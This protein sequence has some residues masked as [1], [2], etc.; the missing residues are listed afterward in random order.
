M[1]I[2]K[3]QVQSTVAV[4][5]E[6]PNIKLVDGYPPAHKEHLAKLDQYKKIVY[7]VVGFV[8]SRAKAYPVIVWEVVRNGWGFTYRM[9]QSFGTAMR[10]GH[11]YPLAGPKIHDYETGVVGVDRVEYTGR[12]MAAVTVSAVYGATF[13]FIAMGRMLL[14]VGKWLG[15]LLWAGIVTAAFK[16]LFA[17]VLS[18]M[19]IFALIWVWSYVSLIDPPV[20]IGMASLVFGFLGYHKS[21]HFPGLKHWFNSGV[22]KAIG[23]DKKKDCDC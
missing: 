17:L 20:V 9:M 10:D 19:A 1:G 16:G 12:L 21:K 6:K 23:E 5:Q 11:L 4:D 18:V 3:E 7:D 13:L 8:K 14:F 22:N 2:E 15:R